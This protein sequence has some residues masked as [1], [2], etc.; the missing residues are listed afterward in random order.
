MRPAVFLDRDGTIN[1]E[2]IYLRDPAEF[3][4]LPGAG[5]AIRRLNQ[6]GWAVVVVSNQSGLARGY[7]SAETLAAIHQ[8]LTQDLAREEAYLD[9][10][11]VCP[12]QPADGCACRKP[13]LALF[14]QAAR[15]L[16]LNLAESVFIGDKMTDLQPGY[17]LGRPTTLV[18]TGHGQ[19]E[20][21]QREIWDFTPSMVVDSL[22]AAVDWLLS[23]EQTRR[24][25]SGVT[26]K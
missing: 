20:W 7:F 16:S 21:A 14:E 10:I 4:L 12:H 8:R 2:R 26:C 22:V 5:Q 3:K 15:E 17:R 9:G 19:A 18:L 13:G 1:E 24:I 6:A 11:Y 23:R 25:S